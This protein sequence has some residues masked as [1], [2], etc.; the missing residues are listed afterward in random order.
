MVIKLSL[1]YWRAKT[2]NHSLF[3]RP[4]NDSSFLRNSSRCS[5]GVTNDTIDYSR[6]DTQRTRL[7]VD[8][9]LETLEHKEKWVGRN[10]SWSTFE[11]CCWASA[12]SLATFTFSKIFKCLFYVH[13]TCYGS[14][15]SF[16]SGWR[17]IN[18][19]I[20]LFRF[21]LGVAVKSLHNLGLPSWISG[22]IKAIH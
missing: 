21:V 3:S 8:F 18:H 6:A 13:A 20:L 2:V 14:D 12:K 10:F 7:R 1:G 22:I 4:V 15:K 17:T 16:C 9:C 19:E 11:R 5:V